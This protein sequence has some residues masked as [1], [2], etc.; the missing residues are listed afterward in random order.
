MIP[1]SSF[2]RFWS[3]ILLMSASYQFTNPRIGQYKWI[4]LALIL[5]TL[6][7]PKKKIW[8]LSAISF[9]LIFYF[10][11]LPYVSMSESTIF[12]L[13]I[14]WLLMNGFTKDEQ[15]KPGAYYLVPGTIF[16]ISAIHKLNDS[17]FDS[18]QSCVKLFH[19]WINSPFIPW[20][21]IP[22]TVIFLYF[23][24]GFS[25]FTKFR[26]YTWILMYIIQAPFCF[27]GIW[28]FAIAT[29]SGVISSQFR[30]ISTKRMV[31]VAGWL[32]LYIISVITQK[33]DTRIYLASVCTISMFLPFLLDTLSQTNVPVPWKREYPLVVAMIIWC[34]SPYWGG[35]QHNVFSMF[36]NLQLSPFFSNSWLPNRG[37]EISPDDWVQIVEEPVIAEGI[38]VPV[39]TRV[40]LQQWDKKTPLYLPPRY[41]YFLLKDG[42]K[43]SFKH[44]GQRWEWPGNA[45]DWKKQGHM[46]NPEKRKAVSRGHC[47]S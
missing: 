19:P 8:T 13:N 34:M 3:V 14:H 9:V 23:L 17:F 11:R 28:E 1:F 33:D 45:S 22:S 12:L 35:N 4:E 25:Q 20:V 31:W 41:L 21:V 6:I 42:V 27:F 24:I 2:A 37:D 10:F 47:Q 43:V 40:D 5:L 16:I 15:F 36:S 44:K 32:S 26:K 18:T 30:E 46:K 29:W 38:F 39:P 7:F